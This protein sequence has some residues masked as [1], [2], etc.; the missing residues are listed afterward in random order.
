MRCVELDPALDQQYDAVWR[1]IDWPE[2]K[3]NPDTGIDLVTRERDSGREH[4]DPVQVLR[5]HSRAWREEHH[6]PTHIIELIKKVATVTVR[7]VDRLTNSY[8]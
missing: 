8:G 3:G 1:W 5:A 7:T 2:R 6:D 4:N